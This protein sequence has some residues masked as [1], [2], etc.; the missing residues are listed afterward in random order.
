MQTMFKIN[1]YVYI[2]NAPYRFS[3]KEIESLI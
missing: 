3:G 2:T 1:Q